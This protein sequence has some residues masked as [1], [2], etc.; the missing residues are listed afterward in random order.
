MKNS[1]I[2]LIGVAIFVGTL[3][4]LMAWTLIVKQAVTNQLAASSS[5]TGTLTSLAA[6]AGVKL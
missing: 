3:A 2:V 5:G 4:A 1:H 6:L